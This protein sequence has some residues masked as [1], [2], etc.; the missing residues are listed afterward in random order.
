MAHGLTFLFESFV[1][2]DMC[3]AHIYVDY[4]YMVFFKTT[5]IKKNFDHAV[6]PGFQNRK[7]KLLFIKIP[8]AKKFLLTSSICDAGFLLNPFYK[9]PRVRFL[10]MVRQEIV[11]RDFH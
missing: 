3:V 8:R 4:T 5:N 11:T 9:F 2:Y 6:E 1:L 10:A 7:I